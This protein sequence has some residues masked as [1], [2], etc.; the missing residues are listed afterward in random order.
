MALL[1]APTPNA[2]GI[3]RTIYRHKRT[4]RTVQRD[5]APS[6]TPTMLFSFV[7][8]KASLEAALEASLVEGEGTASSR[9]KPKTCI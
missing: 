7:A 6:L 2:A 5:H 3:C 1:E 4:R 8:R 9:P